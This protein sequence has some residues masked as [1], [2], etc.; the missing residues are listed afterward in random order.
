MEWTPELGDH[1]VDLHKHWCDT[2]KSV[3]KTVRLPTT[4]DVEDVAIDS[5][6]YVLE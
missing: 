4:F 6:I 1:P 3:S 2:E 5:K